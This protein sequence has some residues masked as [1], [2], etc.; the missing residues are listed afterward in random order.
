MFFT[1]SMKFILKK[2][3]PTRARVDVLGIFVFSEDKNVSES[4]AFL[5]AP[6]KR[7][8]LKLA[9]KA[10]F[11]GGK[12]TRLLF[13]TH[14]KLR[15]F[16]VVFSGMGSVKDDV[17]TLRERVRNASARVVQSAGRFQAKSVGFEIPETLCAASSKI[18]GSGCAAVV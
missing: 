13:H 2:S 3:K 8:V 12:N 6:L 14:S 7:E 11:K 18:C 5:P 17:N 16:L 10:K 15:S 1:T 4:T 9:E